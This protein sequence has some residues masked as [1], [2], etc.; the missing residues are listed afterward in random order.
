VAAWSGLPAQTELAVVAKAAV[1]E[2]G[3]PPRQMAALVAFLAVA[4]AAAELE[5]LVLRLLAALAA[6][7]LFA[8][9]LGEG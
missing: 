3:H 9:T 1:A 2:M 4:V 5:V 6:L 8:C 7:A